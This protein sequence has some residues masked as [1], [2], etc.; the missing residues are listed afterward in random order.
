MTKHLLASL[1]LVAAAAAEARAGLLDGFDTFVERQMHQWRV[2]GAAVVVVKNGRILLDKGYGQ[3]S[4]A[5]QKPVTRKTIFA[6]ASATKPF[7]AIGLATLVDEGKLDWDKPV[8]DY[9]PEFRLSDPTASEHA[10]VRDL[11]THR[12]GLPRYEAVWFQSP[13]SREDILHRLR[14]LDPSA[15]LRA[16]FQYNNLTFMVAGYLQGRVDGGRS[17]EDSAKARILEPL[18]MAATNFSVEASRE[19]EDYALPYREEKKQLVEVPFWNFANIGPSGAINSNAEDMTRFLRM[20]VNR[21]PISEKRLVSEAQLAVMESAQVPMPGEPDYPL[22][23]P[24]SCGLGWFVTTYRGHKLV[25]HPGRSGGF[26]ALVAFLPHEGIGVVVLTN[27]ASS[28]LPD[29]LAYNVWDRALGLP[30]E[31]WSGRMKRKAEREEKVAAEGDDDSAPRKSGT[32]PSHPLVDFVGR[33]EH[34]A[35]GTLTVTANSQ[36]LAATFNESTA[37]LEHFHYDVFRGTAG[38]GPAGAENLLADQKLQ[39]RLDVDGN[40][41]A[42]LWDVE[43]AV[44][45]AVFA[46]APR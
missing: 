15:E 23:G 35:F 9:L 30:A 5:N 24:E 11:V 40:V 8:R 31:D 26:T 1:L 16:A 21:G 43:A 32:Q 17:W 38:A 12:V 34:P 4:V 6:L 13:L 19:H 37:K 29:I 25:R 2:P 7:T 22:L 45:R 28:P 18:G 44:P 41:D 3:R 27:K 42:I 36:G 33:Y 46:R 14:F 10:T 39:F 20:L